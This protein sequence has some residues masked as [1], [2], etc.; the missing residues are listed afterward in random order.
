MNNKENKPNQISCPNCGEEIDV[1]AMLGDQVRAEYEKI[2]EKDQK[3]LDDERAEIERE[4][5]A[6]AKDKKDQDQAVKDLVAKATKEQEKELEKQIKAKVLE[7]HSESLDDMKKEL[8]EKSEQVSELNKT[9]VEVERLKRENNE[10]EDKYKAESEVELNRVIELEKAKIKKSE[11][12]KHDLEKRDLQ[13]QIDDQKKLTEDMRRKQE[14]GSMREQGEVQELAIEEWLKSEFP[15]DTIEEIKTGKRGADTL[16]TVYTNTRQNCGLIY[17]ESKRTKTFSNEWIEKFK[18]D[19]QEKNANIGILVTQA[20]PP[21]MDRLGKKDGIWICTYEE[22]KGL[23]IVLRES[24]ITISTVLVSQENKGEKKTM[25]YDYLT[26][27]EFRMQIEGIVEGFKQMKADLDSEKR[28]MGSIWKKREKQI[29]KVLHNTTAM[30][31]GI[32]GIAGNAIQVPS[33]E[34]P[35]S[36]L[37]LPPSELELPPSEDE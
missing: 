26:G 29:D 35:P 15:F 10:L 37:E 1:Q 22:F 30:Y 28:S 7:E 6:I 9:K 27:N 18:R 33:L 5:E 32:K 34:L 21:G 16:Q 12:E 13:K 25:L 8:S 24:L 17:Y 19:I 4:K 14:Q 31:G 20:M 23:A 3:K 36:E 11:N 2:R